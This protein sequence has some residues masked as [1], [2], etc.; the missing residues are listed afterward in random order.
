[1]MYRGYVLGSIVCV[2]WGDLN[3]LYVFY[4][5]TSMKKCTKVD[6]GL[7]DRSIVFWLCIVF[8]KNCKV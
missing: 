1:M 6:S 4:K 3:N 5:L 2:R 8:V 7:I